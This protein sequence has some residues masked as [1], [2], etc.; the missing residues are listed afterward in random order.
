MP[1]FVPLK[2]D[3]SVMIVFAE[4]VDSLRTIGLI[5]AKGQGMRYDPIFGNRKAL[6]D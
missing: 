5:C 3:L 4:L 1:C 6:A 2:E